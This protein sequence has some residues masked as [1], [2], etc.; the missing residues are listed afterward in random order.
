MCKLKI[1]C[2]IAVIFFTNG[3]YAQ[4][5]QL[6]TENYPP[7]NMANDQ[8]D[9][10][11]V[12]TEIVKRLFQRANIK[13]EMELLPWQRAYSL[14]LKENDHAVF[15]TTRT[16]EREALFKWVGPI[17]GNNW[18]FLKKEDKDIQINSLED[19]KKYNVGG[20]SGDAVSLYLES[21]GFKIDYVTKDYLNA[22]KLD[23]DR[24]DLW[25][26][27]Q[28]LGPYY[29]KENNVHCLEEA[30]VFKETVMAIAFNLSTDDAIINKLNSELSKMYQDGAIERIRSKFR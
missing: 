4:T 30:F 19:A 9:I 16:T 2:W 1:I 28:L 23:H 7:F 18:I 10:V 29:A 25:A 5:F 27:G 14:A 17:I 8:G 22:R 11:G 13:Y 6:K 3:V 12:S 15:S 26:T 21:Q 20:Y 24:I